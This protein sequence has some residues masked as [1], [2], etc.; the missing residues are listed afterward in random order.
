MVTKT[1]GGRENLSAPY[2]K[3]INN[4]RQKTESGGKLA[5]VFTDSAWKEMNTGIRR[6]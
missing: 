1:P 4:A 2:G 5:S 6:Y 3:S